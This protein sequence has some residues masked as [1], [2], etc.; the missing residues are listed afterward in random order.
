MASR[1]EQARKI[2][3][4]EEEVNALLDIDPSNNNK[5]LVWMAQQKKMGHSIEDISGT[6]QAFHRRKDSL[7]HSDIYKYEDLKVLENEI[8]ALNPSKAEK[9]DIS[10]LKAGADYFCILDNEVCT[11]YSVH[12]F[13]GM[14]A[15]GKGTKWC[16]A[17]NSGYWKSYST[18]NN[19]FVIQSKTDPTEKFCLLTRRKNYNNG[20]NEEHG[21]YD[22]DDNWFPVEDI[23]C[24]ELRSA[25]LAKA[26]IIAKILNKNS[27]NATQYKLMMPGETN[28]KDELQEL[29]GFIK[30]NNLYHLMLYS[31]N[32]K[33]LTSIKNELPKFLGKV[34]FSS[35]ISSEFIKHCSDLIEDNSIKEYILNN[36]CSKSILLSKIDYIN[37]IP[38]SEF[39]DLI[40]NC[41]H[42]TTKLNLIKIRPQHINCLNK[43]DM[44]ISLAKTAIK[45]LEAKALP[46][47]YH[48]YDKKTR[49]NYYGKGGNYLLRSSIDELIEKANKKTIESILKQKDC[50]TSLKKILI[51]TTKKE[52]LSQNQAKELSSLLES[53]FDGKKSLTLES[54]KSIIESV[55]V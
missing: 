50:P 23:L 38:D 31:T 13:R 39:R 2:L 7:E 27:K 46:L 44:N 15:L 51:K 34:K 20:Y 4:S 41:K 6:V 5:Y 37:S 35:V 26:E 47:V 48:L 36:T 17:S 16:V 19:L 54:A 1:I 32:T 29:I 52:T 25:I 14:N 43:K 9:K 45:Q 53:I 18:N 49:Y 30:D 40:K 11:V 12:S 3:S 22:K 10:K 33:L 55:T 21:I 42:K 28:S 8:L 24:P